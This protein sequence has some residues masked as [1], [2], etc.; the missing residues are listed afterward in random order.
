[1]PDSIVYRY[2]PEGLALDARDFL[3]VPELIDRLYAA[4][5]GDVY[6]RRE[7]RSQRASVPAF[8]ESAS[9]RHGASQLLAIPDAAYERGLQRVADAVAETRGRDQHVPSAFVLV[10]ITACKPGP[11]HDA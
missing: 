3:P 10:V 7:D 9:A 5:F 2:F 6:A 1:M 11:S 4:G 8:L